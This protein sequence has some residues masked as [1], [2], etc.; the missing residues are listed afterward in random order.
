MKARLSTDGGARGNPGPAAFAYVLETDDGTVLDARGE[1]IGV[2]T[3]NVAE[4]TAALEGLRK[5]AELGADDVLLRS[6]SRLLIEQLS[7][8]YRVKNPTLQRLHAE[9][10]SVAKTFKRVRYEHVR[11][12]L[13]K[14]AD[15]LANLGVDEWLDAGGDPTPPETA[16]PEPLWEAPGSRSPDGSG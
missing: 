13:N 11:R 10:R 15:R 5:A 2:A 6:D 7:G 14:E 3:N 1:A 4:Y 9:V 12:E 16:T 8:R